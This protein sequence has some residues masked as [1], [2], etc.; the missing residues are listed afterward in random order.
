[1]GRETETQKVMAEAAAQMELVARHMAPRIVDGRLV[2]PSWGAV[3]RFLLMLH[4]RIDRTIAEELGLSR[5]AVANAVLGYGHCSS[6]RTRLH[7]ANLLGESEDVL[8]PDRP[9]AKVSIPAG[10]KGVNDNVSDCACHAR[11]CA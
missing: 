8:F 7:L 9:V 6:K 3:R 5:Q 4:G 2:A 11:K 10:E 1:M